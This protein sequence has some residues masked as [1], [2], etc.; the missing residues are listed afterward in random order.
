MHKLL[1]LFFIFTTFV[2]SND[3]VEIYSSKVETKDNIV[4]ASGNVAVVYKDYYL[5]ASRAVYSKE[6]SE[7]ELFE[8][9]KANQGLDYKLLG[10]YA[11]LN[12]KNKE[13]SFQ[14][15]YM[16]ERDSKVWLSADKCSA[17][18]S[19]FDISSGIVSSCDPADP[20]WQIEFTSSD[21]D[22]DT[23]WLNLYNTRFY[24]YDIPV[25]YMPWFGYPLDKTRRTGLLKPSAGISSNEGFYYE[26]PIYIAPSDSWDLELKPQLRTER[27]Q[28]LYA[29]FRFTDSN[30]SKG[31]FT[32]GFFNEKTSYYLDKNLAN[33][34]HYGYNFLYE[35]S[36]FLNQWFNLKLD[37]QSGIYA[38]I[39]YMNDVDYINLASN[40]PIIVST[41]TQVLSRVNLFYN[42]EDDY[43]GSYFKY[44]QDLTV[45][46]NE[47]TLQ[48]IPTLQYHHYLETLYDDHILY[49][50][51][52]QSNN[53][54][55][56]IN[57][58]VV[59]TDAK[60]PLSVHTSLFDEYLDLKYTTNLYAQHSAFSGSEQ[61]P[62]TNE[63]KN[64]YIA[65]NDNVVSAST[66]LAKAYEDFTHVV[67]LGSSYTFKGAETTNGFYAYNKEFCQDSANN[68]DPRCEFYSIIEVKEEVQIDFS[69][70]IYDM[71]GN[72]KLYHRLS[73]NI[74]YTGAG[75]S[76]GEL[77]NELEYMLTDTLGIYNNMFFNHQRKKFSKVYNKLSYDDHGLDLSLS[78]LYKDTF[79]DLTPTY[80]PYTSYMTSIAKYAYDEHYSYH[81]AYDYDIELK[82]KKRREIG[83]LYKKRC[84]DFG[85][86]YVENNRPVLDKTGTTSNVYERYIYFTISL[87]PFMSTGEDSS[88]FALKL[89]EKFEGN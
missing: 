79:L 57:K 49:N 89:H 42:T 30:V 29:T 45:Q 19:E 22:S 4:N 74:L 24:I 67:S 3:K 1:I 61:T 44:Y 17:K 82:R 2:Y 48:K 53:I 69:Q 21:Y 14:P 6:T 32:T 50:V 34:S 37:G 64:G 25:L 62:T 55:R 39:N 12:I 43:F 60:I 33:D 36:D 88:L 68:N 63:Y 35:N 81:L 84:W 28:G 85:L 20:L 23:K 59:Q 87:K 66:K 5:S 72:Q 31:E 8:N 27:G 11:K 70:Y 40:N 65:R 26:Q 13:K 18:D 58:R 41:S 16:L 7:L 46:S 56:D 9:V 76:N 75:S 73:Q 80:S 54:Y 10:N 78:H 15:F 77:E 83:F 52:I 51:D 86:K 38:D 71:L 47:N